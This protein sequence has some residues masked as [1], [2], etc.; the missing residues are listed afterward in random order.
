MTLPYVLAGHIETLLTA[1]MNR[2]CNT[3]TQA[4]ICK[5]DLAETKVYKKASLQNR[6]RINTHLRVLF[7]QEVFF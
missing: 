1:N 7:G 3:H 5:T 4:L 2:I 6:V